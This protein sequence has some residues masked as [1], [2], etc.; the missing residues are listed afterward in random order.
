M[1]MVIDACHSA[2]SVEGGAFKPG[3]MGSK[4]LGQMAYDKGMRIL[5]STRADDLA[6]ESENTKQGLLSFALVQDGI[7]DGKADYRPTDGSIGIGEWLTYGTERVPQLYR[8]DRTRTGARS[9][10]RLTVFDSNKHYSR[11]VEAGNGD[12]TSQAQRPALF[13]YRR[14]KDPEL[15]RK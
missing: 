11:V 3:P 13:S 7:V 9:G 5:A 4:G 15:V 10:V 2:A 14:E 6:W 8:D 1:V 12:V